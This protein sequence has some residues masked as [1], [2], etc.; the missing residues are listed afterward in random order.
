MNYNEFIKRIHNCYPDEK[1]LRQKEDSKQKKDRTDDEKNV[2]DS[3]SGRQQFADTN[4]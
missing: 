3:R 1:K 4:G 2:S